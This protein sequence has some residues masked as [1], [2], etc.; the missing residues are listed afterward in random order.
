M[1]KDLGRQKPLSPHIS[2]GTLFTDSPLA[3]VWDRDVGEASSAKPCL[4]GLG[5]AS[6]FAPLPQPPG[7]CWHLQP[8]SR[9]SFTLICSRGLWLIST[10]PMKFPSPS[11]EMA[12]FLA[13]AKLGIFPFYRYLRRA[14]GTLVFRCWALPFQTGME[15]EGP[16]WAMLSCNQWPKFHKEYYGASYSCYQVW[17]ELFF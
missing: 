3:W 10:V 12:I 13:K 17:S 11:K 6:S 9:D 8:F 16:P 2:L 14:L 4:G 1:H 7:S 5:T 15:A